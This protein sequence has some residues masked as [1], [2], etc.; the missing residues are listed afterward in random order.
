MSAQTD[1]PSLES[2][3]FIPYLDEN[4]RLHEDL[5][6]KIGV[7]AIFDRN[8]ALQLV[9]YSR[10]VYLSLLQHM[11]R[12]PNQC[13]WFK[14]Q[15]IEHPSRTVLETIRQAWMSENGHLPPGNSDREAQWNQPI[16]VKPLMSA[17]EASEYERLP[18]SER[19]KQLKKIARRVEAEVLDILKVRGA[20]V[21]I[22][23]DPKLKEQGLLDV[24]SLRR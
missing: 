1:I 18:E 16:D 3:E 9:A 24:I 15:T 2:L 19:P 4:G 23:F 12:Q 22:R 21:E 14:I 17:T 7:Y 10:N 5:Q 6:G 11:T 13:H 20:T 8:R